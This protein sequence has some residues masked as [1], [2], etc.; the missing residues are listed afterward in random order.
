[1]CLSFAPVSHAN[2]AEILIINVNNTSKNYNALQLISLSG[3]FQP[4]SSKSAVEILFSD[5]KKDVNIMICV[6]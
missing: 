2:V 4:N 5:F 6:I 1:M 3:S